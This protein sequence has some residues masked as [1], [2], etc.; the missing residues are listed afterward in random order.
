[1]NS[2]H[3]SRYF[4]IFLVTTVLGWSP[5]SAQSLK[6][7]LK[8]GFLHPVSTESL[9]FPEESSHHPDIYTRSNGGF[10]FDHWEPRVGAEVRFSPFSEGLA[11]AAD[12]SYSRLTGSG[13]MSWFPWWG[14]NAL[15][16]DYEGRLY[17]VSAGAQWSFLSGPV[18]P[19]VGARALWSRFRLIGI[20][21]KEVSIYGFDYWGLALLGG[22]AFDLISFL[23]LDIGAR[24]NFTRIGNHQEVNPW[25]STYFNSL[26]IDV[27]LFFEVL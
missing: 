8:G 13:W 4:L 10:G 15:Y 18:H 9:A 3:N 25:L 22:A 16:S 24:Y 11:F 21:D 23:A 27:S 19:Y 12:A 17:T 7:G 5:T 26:S 1:M 14:D 6:L 20:N 2:P